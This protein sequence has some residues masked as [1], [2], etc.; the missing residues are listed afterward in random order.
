MGPPYCD[1][2]ASGG[3]QGVSW[4][5]SFRKEPG[6]VPLEGLISCPPESAPVEPGTQGLFYLQ[7]MSRKCQC[8]NRNY[9]GNSLNNADSPNHV[10]STLNI[11]HQSSFDNLFSED[12]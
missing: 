1:P 8:I 3:R 5:R 9:A 12:Y 10:C 11:V 7:K 6:C 2:A 4:P